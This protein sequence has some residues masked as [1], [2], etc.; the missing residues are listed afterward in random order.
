MKSLWSITAPKAEEKIFSKHPT[1]KPL[2]LL[3]RILL[4]S[5][6]KGD[7][8]LD[9]FTGSSTTGVAA[10][11]LGRYFIGID[12]N[13]DYLDLSVKRL[14]HEEKHETSIREEIKHV[15]QQVESVAVV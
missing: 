4:A 12:N 3:E 7:I 1:Q 5:T 10:Y 9:P 2:A 13:K 6:K 14:K 15:E 11:R 8:V